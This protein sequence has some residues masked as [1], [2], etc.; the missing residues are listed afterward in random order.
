MEINSWFYHS[1]HGWRCYRRYCSCFITALLNLSM[2]VDS[3]LEYVAGF[4]FGLF[5]FQALFMK[6]MLG[7]RYKEAVRKTD[8]LN[9][10]L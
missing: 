7:S 9:G 8:I 3:L 4:A 5:V 2:G 10:C 1:L 6:D